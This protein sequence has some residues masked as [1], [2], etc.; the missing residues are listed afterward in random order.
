MHASIWKQNKNKQSSHGALIR[1]KKGSEFFTGSGEA[2]SSL[3]LLWGPST[4]CSPYV[5]S[6]P[7]GPRVGVNAGPLD[8]GPLYVC[9]YHCSV[10][11]CKY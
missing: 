11:C 7:L 6:L 1:E 10:P 4:P 5:W 2:V 9:F 8:Q 3:W